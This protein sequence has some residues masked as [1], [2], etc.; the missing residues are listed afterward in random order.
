MHS[1]RMRTV[2]SSGHPW[3]VCLEVGACWGVAARG[4]SVCVE[5]LLRGVCLG[6]GVCLEGVA[7]WGCLC[8]GGVDPG[9]V[10]L[11]V[12]ARHPA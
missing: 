9:G 8:V 7:A 5:C 10:C 3:G 6:M 4:V 1:S 11:G 2:R 12:S